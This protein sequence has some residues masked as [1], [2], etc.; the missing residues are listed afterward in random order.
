VEAAY[1]ARDSSNFTTAT[2]RPRLYRRGRVRAGKRYFSGGVQHDIKRPILCADVR[3][4]IG[5]RQNAAGVFFCSYIKDADES[6]F[7]KSY[8]ADQKKLYSTVYN[9][10][11]TSYAG[12]FQYK[13]ISVQS[14][15][16]RGEVRQGLRGAGRC[17]FAYSSSKI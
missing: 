17:S 7:P 13:Y 1:F 4:Y 9:M 12:F 8:A 5:R 11:R 14:E 15:E 16:V 3:F 6:F 10:T 2:L